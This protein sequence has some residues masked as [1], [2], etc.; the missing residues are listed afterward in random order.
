MDIR[1]GVQLAHFWK[2]WHFSTGNNQLLQ[3]NW[4]LLTVMLTVTWISGFSK[5][6]Q[7]EPNFPKMCQI[8]PNFDVQFWNQFLIINS[9]ST[10]QNEWN[11][12]SLSLALFF[13]NHNSR[14]SN[15]E[16]DYSQN[17]GLE[18]YNTISDRIFPHFTTPSIK[19][20]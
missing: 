20:V 3:I 10:H 7:K 12:P 17:V 14:V 9:Y 1:V 18:D 6:S 2:I 5:K 8:H 16:S 11:L 19:Y 13:F 15:I 4:A